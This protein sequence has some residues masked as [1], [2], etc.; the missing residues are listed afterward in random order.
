MGEWGAHSHS[1]T[2]NSGHLACHSCSHFPTIPHIQK[3]NMSEHITSE[4]DEDDFHT[5]DQSDDSDSDFEPCA[6]Y[7]E[8]PHEGKYYKW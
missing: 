1:L 4:K 6:D 8:L 7:S 5:D 3:L 2:H